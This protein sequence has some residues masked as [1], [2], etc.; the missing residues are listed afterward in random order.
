VGCAGM[1]YLESLRSNPKFIQN[2][3]EDLLEKNQAQPVGH[4]YI[5]II[6]DIKY[7]ERL[8][9]E[10]TQI[11]IVIDGVT[12]WCHCSEKNKYLYECPHG[13]GGPR[14]VYFEG[15]YSE[16]GIDYE[17][18]D[19]PQSNF[20]Q[21]E[22]RKVLLSEIKAINETTKR[23]IE[24]FTKDERFS[25]CFTPAIWLHVPKEWKRI[26]YMKY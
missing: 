24:Q 15:W 17:S 18:F 8:I 4:G 7:L 19:I 9:S 12:W 10:L 6:T 22:N 25:K 23:Y 14:S 20:E 26:K 2:Q 13:M 5:D 11:G 1:N 21:L 16:M 3:I